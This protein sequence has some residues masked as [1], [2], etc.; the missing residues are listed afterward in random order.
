MHPCRRTHATCHADEKARQARSAAIAQ[1][2]E[3]A[4]REVESEIERRNASGYDKAAGL[5]LDLQAVA[6][7]RGTMPDFTKR[8]RAMRERHAHK[9]PFIERLVEIG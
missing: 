4:W 5:L 1:R 6:D 3:N 7:E 2:G 8:L 9:E